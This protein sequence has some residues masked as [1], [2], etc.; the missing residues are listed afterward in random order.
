MT[1]GNWRATRLAAT[2]AIALGLAA[3]VRAGE[4]DL[5]SPDTLLLTGDVRF[6][7]VNGER[8]W[9]D[10]GF[11]K[12]RFGGRD[13]SSDARV[14]GALSGDLVWQ[15]KL[16][17][18]LSAT[19]VGSLQQ[20]D[21]LEAGLSEAYVSFRPLGSAKVKFSARAGLM[22]PPVS[23]EHGGPEW[24]VRDTIT[25]SAINSWIGEEVKFVGAE[26]TASVAVGGGSLGLT[27]AVVDADDTAGALLA[28]R[29]WSL[30]DL[31]AVAW[32]KV[33]LPELGEGIEPY[34]PY[35]THP[36]KEMDGGFLK[37]PGWYARAVWQLGAPVRI[38][39]IHF[40]NGGDPDAADDYREWGWRTKFENVGLTASLGPA[41]EL[42]AQAMR[43]HT[44]M[45]FYEGDRRLVDMRFRSA[46]ALLT[47]RFGD[48][49]SISVRGEGFATRNHGSE[50][51][52]DDN[53]HGWA[54]TAAG[55]HELGPN[56]AG[57]VE[58]LHVDS[59]RDARL[60]D[61]LAPH[62][63]QTQLQGSLRLRW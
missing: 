52:A 1:G 7:A 22:W 56:L 43:G 18:A 59:H 60:R 54:V 28:Y 12:L 49:A 38:E 45:G 3:P 55:K 25:P 29:G 9:V 36:L 10:G 32:R 2:S 44:L 47:Q 63:R 48:R 51:G 8:S 21:K 57:L 24:A 39:A 11:G 42:R 20:R 19:V 35:F 62:Q 4:V 40:D 30:H 27:G 34:Q 6:A 26:G 58:L 53:E 17:W 13:G 5:L 16:G 33:P 61:G 41:T 46:F 15:P 37:R 50:M 23:L 31:K 14:R